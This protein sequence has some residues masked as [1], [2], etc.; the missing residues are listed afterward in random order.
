MCNDLIRLRAI[1][2]KF[3]AINAKYQIYLRLQKLKNLSSP[4]LYALT[5]SNV[6]TLNRSA[7]RFSDYVN[8]EVIKSYYYYYIII[9]F[10]CYVKSPGGNFASGAVWHTI[11]FKVSGFY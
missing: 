2:Y 7:H 3:L 11:V 6:D 8:T 9:I 4:P 5:L 1:R 10:S